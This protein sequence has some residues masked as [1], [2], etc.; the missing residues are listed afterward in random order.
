MIVIGCG[1]GF[2]IVQE[3]VLKLKEMFGIQVEVFLSVE[4][5]YGL[6]ELIDCDYLLFV[7]VLLGFEQVGLLQ[8]VVDMCVCG[9]VVLFVVLVGMFGVLMFGVLG[10]VLL[11][12]QFVYLVFDLIVVIF[13]F[14]VMVVDFVVVCGCNFDMLCY[15]NKVI[16]MY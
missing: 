9:V 3:V 15:L 2:V 4:V 11:F 14:Y 5:C 1:L 16:E 7:F 10:I 8:F 13:L 12:V 6:M